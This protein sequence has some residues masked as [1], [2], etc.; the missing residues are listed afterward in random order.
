MF[1]FH[2]QPKSLKE[3][4]LVLYVM[5]VATNE[6]VLLHI[7]GSYQLIPDLCMRF[8]AFKSFLNN[9]RQWNVF[10]LLKIRLTL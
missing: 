4:K 9:L 10:F 3:I 1:Y 6:F 2:T 7:L 8:L 5:A